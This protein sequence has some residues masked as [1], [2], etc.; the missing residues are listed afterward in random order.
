MVSLIV[1]AFALLKL[2]VLLN[3][4]NPDVSEHIIDQAFGDDD[5]YD[6]KSQDF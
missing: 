1:L 5:Y 3:K 4:L 2:D 6:T